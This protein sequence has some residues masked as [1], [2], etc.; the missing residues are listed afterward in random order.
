MNADDLTARLRAHGRDVARQIA[1]DLEAR[2]MAGTRPLTWKERA[3]EHRAYTQFMADVRAATA[4][5]P[6]VYRLLPEDRDLILT[7][8]A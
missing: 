5:P 2:I 3:A 7:A 4:P 1:L 8:C 6:P